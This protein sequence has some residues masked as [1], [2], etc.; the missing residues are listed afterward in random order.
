MVEEELRRMGVTDI[1]HMQ[2]PYGH[3][4]I[5]GLLNMASQEIAMIHASQVPY[6]VC[7]ALKKKGI[8]LLECRHR[9]KQKRGWLS[10]L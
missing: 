4:H 7:D 10:T 2:I 5:D 6:D 8:K 1:L 9:L 3:A